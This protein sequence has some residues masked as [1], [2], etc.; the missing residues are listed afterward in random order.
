MYEFWDDCMKPKYGE[1][2]LCYM[3][4]DRFIVHVKTD[5]IAKT[6]WMLKKG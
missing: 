3:D 2:K 5:S 6:L 4:R 1:K